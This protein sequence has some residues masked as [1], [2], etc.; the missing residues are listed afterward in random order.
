MHLSRSVLAARF[1]GLVGVPPMHYLAR[2][3]LASAAR[4]LGRERS[5]LARIAEAVGYESEAAFNRAFKRE[6]G[7]SPG[8]WRRGAGPAQRAAIGT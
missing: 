5:N 3:R 8:Q 2:W 7:V 4:L 6:Y 1:T